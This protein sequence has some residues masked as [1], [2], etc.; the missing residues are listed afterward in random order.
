MHCAKS[1]QESQQRSNVVI[2]IACSEYGSE[3]ESRHEQDAAGQRNLPGTRGVA[4]NPVL[5]VHSR[6]QE[7]G[8]D[9]DHQDLIQPIHGL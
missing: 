4:R 3:R 7:Q 8:C 9:K 5:R 6:S 1:D 2:G